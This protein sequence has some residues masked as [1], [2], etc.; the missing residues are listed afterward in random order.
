MKTL[1]IKICALLLTIFFSL[2]TTLALEQG[3]LQVTSI[4]P[5]QT[6]ATPDG[7]FENGW[8]WIFNVTVPTNEKV[9]RLKFANWTSGT[10]T[11]LTS[12]NVRFYS[13]QST[14]SNSTS[15]AKILSNANT[16]GDTITLSSSLD[17]SPSTLGRQIQVVV[18]VKVPVGTNGGSYASSYGISSDIDPN[19]ATGI[20]QYTINSFNLFLNGNHTDQIIGQVLVTAQNED[21]KLNTLIWT[22]KKAHLFLILIQM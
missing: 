16:Y 2:N 20:V 11:I 21:V 17:L 10:S 3:T 14:N 8:Q 12:N 5:T 15:T 7:D 4:A 6:L 22:R 18:D 9:V 13:P 1:N 19:Q